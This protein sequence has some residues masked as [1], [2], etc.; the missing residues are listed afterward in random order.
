M[1]RTEFFESQKVFSDGLTFG[2]NGLINRVKANISDLFTAGTIS[3]LTTAAGYG[4]N[5][6]T[7]YVTPGTAYDTDG[8]KINVPVLQYPVNYNGVLINAVAGTYY[9]TAEYAE[10]NDSMV[11]IDLDGVTHAEHIT[12]S[13]KVAVYKS[14]DSVPGDVVQLGQVV[15]AAPGGA[16]TVSSTGRDVMA[17]KTFA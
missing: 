2:F 4:A 10:S 17:I 7:I 8:E 12:E 5:A 11:G 13:Y 15:V 16:L 3:G 14:T 9:I 1:Q 6:G